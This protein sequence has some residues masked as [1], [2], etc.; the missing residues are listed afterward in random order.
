MHNNPQ[1]AV[2]YDDIRAAEAVVGDYVH[3]TPLVS[4]LTFS[5]WTGATVWLKA[6]SLQKTG[7]F[8][9]RGAL[10]AVTNLQADERRRGVITV[11]AG[12]HGMAV[13]YAG[14]MLDTAATV[15]MPDT[16]G[17]NKIAAIEGYG[18]DAVLVDGTKLMESME[19]IRAEHGQVFL[20]PFDHPHVIAGQGTVGLEIVEDFPDVDMVV[21]PVGG[22]GLIS[23]VVTAVKRLNPAVM[24]VGV[25]PEGST[26]VSQS[27]AAGQPLRLS[28]FGTIAD[29]LNAPWS[30]PNTL[31]IVQSLVDYV[32]TVTDDQI[33]QAMVTIA[34][35]TKLLVEP[36]GAAGVAA[37]LLGK[38]RDIENRN[39]VVILSGANVDAQ[40]LSRV[41]SQSAPLNAGSV[42]A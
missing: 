3:R 41:F 6:E 27:L 30:G 22:G 29:G 17:K 32:V 21:V 16:A 12:N 7:S 25:E 37:L 13:A 11:S 24:V 20:H 1:L 15:V 5:E 14:R 9:V 36:A 4:S 26:A 34:Q 38:V 40:V 28:K 10:N 33:A 39:V 42:V 18:A 2:T 19:V 8:K 23:G 35:R 31:A